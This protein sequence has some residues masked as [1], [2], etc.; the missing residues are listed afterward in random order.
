MDFN[1]IIVG[2]NYYDYSPTE[3]KKDVFYHNIFV[4]DPTFLPLNILNIID[5]MTMDSSFRGFDLL[6]IFIIPTLIFVYF[7]FLF[8]FFII[9]YTKI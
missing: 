2:N 4:S 6:I 3:R 8:C 9:I 1:K 7:I 5:I